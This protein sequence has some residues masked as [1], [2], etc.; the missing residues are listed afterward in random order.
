[1]RCE[2]DYPQRHHMP[3]PPAHEPPSKIQNTLCW[4]ADK[5]LTLL[6]VFFFAGLGLILGA[7]FAEEILTALT[8]L[9][10]AVVL[11]FIL[12]VIVLIIKQCKCCKKNTCKD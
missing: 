5:I 12:I 7:V 3:E 6:L 10:V 8:A 2:P 11:L 1:M 4:C 9:I